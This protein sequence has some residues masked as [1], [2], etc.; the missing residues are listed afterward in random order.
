MDSLMHVTLSISS[1]IYSITAICTTLYRAKIQKED[2][3]HKLTREAV[4][5]TYINYVKPLKQQRQ[6]DETTQE[7]ARDMAVD[8]VRKNSSCFC[9]CFDASERRIR[10][11]I[12]EIINQRKHKISPNC[13]R[14]VEI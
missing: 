12:S 11:W 10:S 13:S 1:I 9:V 6:W 3:Q 8:F 2:H 7:I 5:L 4:H 14:Y